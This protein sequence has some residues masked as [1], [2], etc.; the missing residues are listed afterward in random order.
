MKFRVSSTRLLVQLQT[1]SRVLT[2]K[3][4][5]A[6][7]NDFLFSIEGNYLIITSS[8]SETTM[9]STLEIENL[10][11]NGRFCVGAKLLTDTL[12]EFSEQPIEFNVDNDNLGILI[13]SD[14]GEYKF[15]GENADQYPILPQVEAENFQFSIPAAV[16]LNGI[17][18]TIFA[19]ADDDIRPVMTGIDVDLNEQSV[20]FV[21][22]DAHKLVR[23]I[24]TD[25]HADTPCSFILPKKPATLLRNVL[26][27][28]EDNVEVTFDSKNVCFQLPNA[29]IICRRVEGHYPNYNAV[30]PQNNS[31]HVVVDRLSLLN[32]L[33]RVQVFSNQGNSLVKLALS[34][35][36]II[37]SAQDINYSTSAEERVPCQYASEPMN[38]G[39]KSVFLIEILANIDA[40]EVR[41]EIEDPSRA[42]LVLPNESAENENLLMLLM[43]MLLNE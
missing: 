37:V 9:I 26:S 24:N 31:H 25:V 19:T 16:L 20:T 27:K 29:T 13:R 34:D 10:E 30:I 14:Y 17:N 40:T 42:G 5:L 18:R 11:G 3:N 1:L 35:N 2:A 41:L 6:I 22:T 7:L 33:R 36:Q 39:F 43:P 8:D 4:T 32:A 23:Y 38:I 15:V 21:G 28:E 12:K